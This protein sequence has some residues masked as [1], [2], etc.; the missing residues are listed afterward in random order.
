MLT[1]GTNYYIVFDTEVKVFGDE[2]CKLEN[3]LELCSDLKIQKEDLIRNYEALK[4]KNCFIQK[5]CQYLS[6]GIICCSQG[7]E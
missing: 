1:L 7:M 3:L 6:K 4:K 2:K 5:Q